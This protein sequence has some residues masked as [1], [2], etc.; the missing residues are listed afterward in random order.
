VALLMEED[1]QQLDYASRP[2]P[3]PKRKDLFRLVVIGTILG[4]AY[5]AFLFWWTLFR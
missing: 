1:R 3:D 4:I 5:A 2:R